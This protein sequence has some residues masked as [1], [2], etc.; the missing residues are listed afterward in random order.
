VARGFEE[1]NFCAILICKLL[2]RKGLKKTYGK[3]S[4]MFNIKK[5]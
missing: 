2:Q 3:V 5:A 4:E 1:F